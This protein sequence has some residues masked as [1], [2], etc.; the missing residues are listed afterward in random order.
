MPPK[1]QTP[2][3]KLDV[4]PLKGA[5]NQSY[6]KIIVESKNYFSMKDLNTIYKKIIQDN[7]PKK[8]AIK[9]QNPLRW[10]TLK[11]FDINT[12]D[13]EWTDEDYYKSFDD[14]KIREK[15]NKYKNITFFIK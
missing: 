11:N 6:K 13:L 10:V 4:K 12:E 7:D 9:A 1:V 8:I 2:K 5:K 3:Y 15:W 14:V